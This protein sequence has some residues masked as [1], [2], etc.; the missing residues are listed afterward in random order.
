MQ[1]E[2]TGFN[3]RINPKK[4]LIKMNPNELDESNRILE[5]EIKRRKLNLNNLQK[6]KTNM[7]PNS[8]AKTSANNSSI[9]KISLNSNK[10]SF[11]SNKKDFY[12]PKSNQTN[13]TN[14]NLEPFNQTKRDNSEDLRNSYTRKSNISEDENFTNEKSSENLKNSNNNSAIY[15]AKQK[16][17]KTLIPFE[18]NSNSLLDEN[19][20]RKQ[21]V[22]K[23]KCCRKINLPKEKNYFISEKNLELLEGAVNEKECDITILRKLLNMAKDD[24]DNYKNRYE[25]INLY[26][27]NINIEKENLMQDLLK[28]SEEKKLLKENYDEYVDKYNTIRIFNKKIED[29]FED[30]FNMKAMYYEFVEHF[31]D[32]ETKYNLNKMLVIDCDLVEN[33]FVKS[34]NDNEIKEISSYLKLPEKAEF[35]VKYLDIVKSLESKEIDVY[36]RIFG[37][38]KFIKTRQNFFNMNN[39]NNNQSSFA[40]VKD[41]SMYLQLNSLENFEDFKVNND[42]EK[43]SKY[44]NNYLI[45]FI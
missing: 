44:L 6:F 20:Q 36:L 27:E 16:T 24:I 35:I 10:S 21:A 2:K 3:P 32:K 34:E 30:L 28:T 13:Q 26:L 37:R 23:L 1:K 25:N 29:I 9:K 41:T 39:Y 14:K 33:Q 12:S 31:A 45:H 42:Q 5:N 19:K 15:F 22:E 4:D 43:L 17:K 38:K 7:S 8:K 18:L 11:I 40:D